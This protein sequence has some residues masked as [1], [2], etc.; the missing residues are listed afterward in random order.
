MTITNR[1]KWSLGRGNAVVPSRWQATLCKPSQ[2]FRLAGVSCI[3]R[4]RLTIFPGQA[5]VTR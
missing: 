2:P 1:P 5:P 4:V 3:K